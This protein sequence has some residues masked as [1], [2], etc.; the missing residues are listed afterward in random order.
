MRNLLKKSVLLIAAACITLSLSVVTADTVKADELTDAQLLQLQLLM[1]TPEYKAALKA[2]EEAQAAAI[3]QYQAALMQQ[4]QAALL[5]YNNAL[6]LQKMGV[7]QTFLLNSI[8]T[9]Q[10][11]NFESMINKEGLDYKSELMTK[12]TQLQN[13]ALKSYMG[14]YGY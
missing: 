7:N 5:V 13:E 14:Y 6:Y 11:A 8:Q 4:Y 9:Q 12:Y 1:Q 3:A 2:Q 10:K